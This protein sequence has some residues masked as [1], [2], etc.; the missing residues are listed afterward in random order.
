[1]TTIQPNIFTGALFCLPYL[2]SM[3][4][5]CSVAKL[6]PTL[7][8]HGLQLAGLLVLHYLLEFAQIRIHWVVMLSNHLILYRHLLLLPS[9]FPSIRVLFSELALIIRWP[10]YWNFSFSISPSSEYSR[11]ISFR[12]DWFDHL[13]VQVT[14]KRLQHCNSK[15]SIV[16]HSAFFMVQ[17]LT[18]FFQFLLQLSEIPLS[19]LFH[20]FK[21]IK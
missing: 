14:L 21:L 1:M 8:P 2:P 9:I 6:C 12:I 4:C 7:K 20:F 18:T 3:I 13:R 17:T 11:L 16:W 19:T 5:C 15:A 10:K